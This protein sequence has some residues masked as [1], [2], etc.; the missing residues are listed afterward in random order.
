[1]APK[2]ANFSKEEELLLQDFGRNLSKK[3]SVIFYVHAIFVSAIPLWLFNRV[4]QME[5][6]DNAVLFVIG[7]L[8]SAYL[9]S[10]AYKNNKFEMKHKIAQKRGEGVAA[11]VYSK[12]A[13]SDSSKKISKKEKDERILWRKNEI[14]E[15]ESMQLAV[16]YSNSLFL[17]VLILSSFYFFKNYTPMFN[18]MVSMVG[19][20][21]VTALLSTSSK[22]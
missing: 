1:M 19:S 22:K 14:A 17:I 13:E 2:Q 7:T 8:V 4:H 18:Y 5:L 6:V 21:A 12:T 3:S 16:F 11:E 15:A 10:M 20:S 9:I